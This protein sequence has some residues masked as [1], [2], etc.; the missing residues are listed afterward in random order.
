MLSAQYLALP[1]TN[2]SSQI[3]WDSATTDIVNGG[4][5]ITAASFQTSITRMKKDWSKLTL[6]DKS[7]LAACFFHM[8]ADYRKSIMASVRIY[9]CYLP[10]LQNTDSQLL[11]QLDQSYQRL[12]ARRETHQCCVFQD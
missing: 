10:P 7:R 11:D 9:S 2:T 3:D 5:E 8:N 4:R 6:P 12:Q 1:V